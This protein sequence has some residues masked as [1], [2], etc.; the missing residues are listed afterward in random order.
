M[1]RTSPLV[2]GSEFARLL[3]FPYGFVDTLRTIGWTGLPAAAAV[4]ALL[5]LGTSALVR[6]PDLRPWALAALVPIV[7]MAAVGLFIPIFC[8]RG[9]IYVLAP[10]AALAAAGSAPRAL[11]GIAVAAILLGTL[12]GVR[13]FNRALERE[14]W[15]DAVD[16]LCRSAAPEDPVL[17]HEGYLGVNVQYYLREA[18]RQI[19][20]VGEWG[21]FTLE[22][23]RTHQKSDPVVWVIRRTYSERSELLRLQR[24]IP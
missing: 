19:T 11:R 4:A 10:L 15:R 21:M 22:E 9:L 18:R 20:T 6:R 7:A 23:I 16:S 12:P 3:A 2:L 24:K 14:N 8:A 17:V 1:E 13:F 5:G